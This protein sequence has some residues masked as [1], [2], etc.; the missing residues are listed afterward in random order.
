MAI[1]FQLFLFVVDP[2]FEVHVGGSFDIHH[3]DVGG[4]EDAKTDFQLLFGFRFDEDVFGGGTSGFWKDID[5]ASE[6]TLASGRRGVI[7]WSCFDWLLRPGLP[8]MRI[9]SVFKID[10]SVTDK[11]ITEQFIVIHSSYSQSWCSRE[12]RIK[13]EFL[14]E[15]WIWLIILVEL[16]SVLFL[17]SQ[18][19]F[20]IWV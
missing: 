16:P 9:E 18:L 5:E 7:Q 4:V 10:E 3:F 20:E 6:F 8:M 2:A 1:G 14:E 12:L 15:I 11:I 17:A 13:H 19:Q